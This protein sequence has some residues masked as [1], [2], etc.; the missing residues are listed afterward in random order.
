MR[1]FLFYPRLAVSG[2]RRNKILYVPYLL[3][4]SLMVMLF[5]ILSSMTW[6][7]GNS[8]IKG[9]SSMSV[10]LML[11]SVVCGLLTVLILFYLNGY[12]I[13]Q[14]S[15]EF[16][17]YS[18]LGLG[19]GN[20]CLL[21]FWEILFSCIGS[22]ICGILAGAV[23]SQLMYLLL[24]NI[25][26]LPVDLEIWV[27]MGAVNITVYLFLAAWGIVLLRNVIRIFR[28]DPIEIL[29]RTSQGEQ[30]PRSRWLIAL[31][32]ACTLTAGYALAL[33]VQDP[34]MVLAIFLPATI[35]V[36]IATY[37]IFSALSIVVL[38]AMRKNRRFYY[39]SD[40]FINVSGM[41]YRMKQNAVGLANICIL[42]SAVL[43]TISSCVCLYIGEE[44]MLDSLYPREVAVTVYRNKYAE[45]P[46]PDLLAA[47]QEI[48]Q[49]YDMELLDPITVTKC[50]VYVHQNGSVIT[51]THETKQI[52]R[53]LEYRLLD[54]LNAELGS[55]Y[56]LSDQEVLVCHTKDFT[57]GMTLQI[58]GSNFTVVTLPESDALNT[59]LTQTGASS[60]PIFFFH[61]KDTLMRAR[62]MDESATLSYVLWFD[63][64][65]EAVNAGLFQQNLYDHLS[66]SEGNFGTRFKSEA[67]TDFYSM[68]GSLLFVGLFFVALFLI[69]TVLIIYYK[70]ITEGYEDRQRF[71]IM[72]QVGLSDAEVRT[73]IRRQVQMVFFLPIIVALV[74]IAFAFPALQKIMTLFEMHNTPLFI[75]CVAV[76]A[77]VFLGF[78][79]GVYLITA[80]TYYHIVTS[81]PQS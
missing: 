8:G 71:R 31:T 23:F 34:S 10:L 19:K 56:T 20:L 50:V 16:G 67:R 57:E 69:T 3:A 54:E 78:Y 53:T 30:E 44:D 66:R 26:R 65:I 1:S 74:H 9:G 70:Q 72:R 22:L 48:A 80:R 79:T 42:A 24:L 43:V 52:N 11:S 36:I 58:D 5:Y 64:D 40:N 47:T 60:N 63:Y 7:V 21:L 59:Y 61:D 18:V 35:L 13:K 46:E 25:T 49:S 41:L 6:I 75:G 4:A 81:A 62:Q 29:R 45:K 76:S 73:S 33:T 39:R 55:S 38:K 77:L 17:L 32:G 28:S 12:V 15:R 51:S 27:P 68:Y 2:M 37:C 14:R